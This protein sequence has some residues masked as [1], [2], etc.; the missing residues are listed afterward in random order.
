MAHEI[1][2]PLTTIRTYTRSLLKRKDLDAQVIQRLN[3]IDRECTQQIDRFSLIFRAVEL[4]AASQMVKS[5]LSA[6]ALHQ[7]FQEAIPQ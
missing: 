2:T 6:I 1:R 5:P 7:V 3:S 4:E